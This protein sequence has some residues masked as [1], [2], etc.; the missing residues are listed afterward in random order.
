MNKKAIITFVTD[1]H[2]QQI[3]DFILSC[4]RECPDADLL[5]YTAENYKEVER[6]CASFDN[7]QVIQHR[8]SILPKIVGKR[9]L[10]SPTGAQIIAR[11]IQHLYQW[12]GKAKG[13]E[14]WLAPLL[15]FKLKRLIM[16]RELMEL[17]PHDQVMLIDYRSGILSG[18]PFKNLSRNMIITGSSQTDAKEV[19]SGRK[20][21]EVIYSSEEL[22]QIKNRPQLSADVV[23]GFRHAFGQY[24]RETIEEIFLHT[25]KIVAMPEAAEAIHA[26]LFYK[27]LQGIDKRVLSTQAT[28]HT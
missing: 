27:R 9:L 14:I 23:V 2:P 4:Q 12:T 3:H 1:Y 19:E 16:I 11:L 15:Q 24:V 25:S 5:I 6:V 28:T 17:H 22:K 7:T 13:L 8:E 10:Q 20:C 21:Y 26:H 18:N